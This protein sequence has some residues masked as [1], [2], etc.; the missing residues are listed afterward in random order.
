M[1]WSEQDPKIAGK[2]AQ[3]LIK[4]LFLRDQKGNAAQ[5]NARMALR[6]VGPPAAA[7]LIKAFEG[8][9]TD[10][11]EFAEIRGL[12]KWKFTQG[13]E[14]VEMLWDVGDPSAS[15]ALMK[16]IGIPLDPPPADVARLPEDQRTEWKNANSNRLATTALT[17][18]ALVNDDAIKYA[19]DLLQRRNPP[20]EASQFVNAG[21]GLALMGTPKSRAALW[22]LFEGGAAKIPGIR[23]KIK[24]L[25]ARVPGMSNKAAKKKAMK[26]HDDLIDEVAI[27]EDRRANF[28]TNLAV[29]LNHEITAKFKAQV[30]DAEK[31][32]LKESA[33]QPLPKAYYDVTAECGASLNCYLNILKSM[34]GKLDSIP[35]A[36]ADVQKELRTAQKTIKAEAKP[37]NLKIKAKSKEIEAKYKSVLA[38][39]AEIEKAQKTKKKVTDKIKTFNAGL[40]EMKVMQVARDKMYDARQAVY[41]KLDPLKAK[42][43]EQQL[44]LYRLEK[45]ALTIG[46]IPG[47]DKHLNT[48][49]AL[50]KEAQNPN[51]QQFRQWSLIAMEHLANKSSAAV[52]EDLVKAESEKGVS[53][54]VLRLQSL[55]QRIT[56]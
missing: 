33:A 28:V 24:K 4:A 41:K 10:I 15:P 35:K 49:A 37:I 39:K 52:I 22:Q 43:A 6:A 36:I 20:P 3:N 46:S 56:R 5:I 34:Q 26:E 32:P 9:N 51:F 30:L 27:I 17:V 54:W 21:L 44:K 19:V 48:V 7:P 18:G 55:L 2:A 50:F 23:A 11:N 47:G 40:D 31:G 29:G 38:L 8:T 13:H 42:F 53:Y 45:A 14:L 12:P 25:K 16:A 1:K